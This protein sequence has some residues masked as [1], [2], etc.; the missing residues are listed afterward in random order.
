MRLP[1]LVALWLGLAAAW[2]F[3]ATIPLLAF[4][5]PL[6]AFAFMAQLFGRTLR[7]GSEPLI[8]RIARKSDPG[9]SSEVARYTRTLTA[10]WSA[11]FVALF[12]ITIFAALLLPPQSGLRL[13]Q[14]LGAAWPIALFAGEYVYRPHRFPLRHR[15]SLAESVRDVLAVFRDIGRESR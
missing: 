9:M 7:S 6:A 3:S 15:A 4:I 13:V 11:T 14:V 10:V 1:A 2:Y 12:V 5:P 8:S